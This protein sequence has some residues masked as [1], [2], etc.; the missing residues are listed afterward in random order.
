MSWQQLQQLITIS[1]EQLQHLRGALPYAVVGVLVAAFAGGGFDFGA[2][3]LTDWIGQRVM[4]DLRNQLTAHMQRLDLAFFNRRR[5]GQI[6]SRVT[7]DVALVRGLVTG[8][9]TSI[10]EDLARLIGLVAMAVRFD[11]LLALVV[12]CLFPAAGLPMRYLS[13]QL[14]QASRR[15]QEGVG[16]LNAMLHENVQGNRVVKAFGQ[17]AHEQRRFVEHNVRL[18]RIFM[19]ASLLRSLPVTEA[20]AGLAIA[21]ILYYGGLRVANNPRSLGNFVGFLFALYMLYEPFRRLVR[22]N[23]TIQQGLAGAERVFELLDTAP[24]VVDR[25]GAVELR[26]VR[27]AIEFH[28]VSFAYDP[29]EPVLRDIELSIP[30]GQ[31]V[32]LVGMSGGGKSTLADLIPRFYDVTAGRITIDGRDIRDLM[33]ASLRAH[34][35]VVTQFTFLFTD[36]VRNNIAYR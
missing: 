17:E 32:A 13:S 21:G 20:F 3:Y 19:R 35:A 1:P 14:R 4:T 25:P 27:E 11:W 6:V 28:D 24:Q 31:V 26:P 36:T 16:R 22:T 5:A 23:Y 2:S 33:L 12:V 8:A 18:F 15:M 9:V 29:G 10:F 7:A 34:I 30:V